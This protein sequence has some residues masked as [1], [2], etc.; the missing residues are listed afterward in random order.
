MPSNRTVVVLAAIPAALIAVTVGVDLTHVAD[1]LGPAYSCSHEGRLAANRIV[2][3]L[4]LVAANHVSYATDA[5]A[6]SDSGR[7][8]TV[9]GDAGVFGTTPAQ[10]EATFLKHFG[11]DKPRHTAEYAHD[12]VGHIVKEHIDGTSSTF[13][14]RIGADLARVTVLN[15]VD[16]GLSV[17]AEPIAD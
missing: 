12:D 3:E 7:H 9:S 1:A 16:D 14:C 2:G 15:Y 17:D 6:D 8:L 4:S 11:C 10:I 13:A 5:C